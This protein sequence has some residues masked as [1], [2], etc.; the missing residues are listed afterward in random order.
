MVFPGAGMG[1]FLGLFLGAMG[2]MQPMRIINGREVPQA[3]LREQV[4]TI[5]EARPSSAELL[6]L[7]LLLFLL[8]FELELDQVGRVQDR[9][10]R[11]RSASLPTAYSVTV[12]VSSLQYARDHGMHV[13][14]GPCAYRIE[15]R[16]RFCLSH[17]VVGW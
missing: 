16:R 12:Q 14:L 9:R 7:L 4:P 8:L 10:A 1:F 11:A 17:D 2:D 3:P 13:L 5:L 6:L 15:F